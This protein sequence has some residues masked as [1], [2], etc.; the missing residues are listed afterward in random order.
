MKKDIHVGDITIACEANAFTPILYRQIFSLDFMAELQGFAKLKGKKPHEYTDDDK[1][2]AL[3]RVSAF[4]RL[5]FC[6]A[7]QGTG[8]PVSDLVGLSKIDF[9]EWLTQFEPLAFEDVGTISDILTLW[10]TNAE[11]NK[12]TAKNA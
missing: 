5:A 2:L 10:R 6:M 4:S 9:Y 3:E 1:A 12:I 7:E 8:K 11:D